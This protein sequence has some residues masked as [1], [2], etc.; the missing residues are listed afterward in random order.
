[1]I[2][3]R[4]RQEYVFLDVHKLVFLLL[5]VRLL[6]CCIDV[7]LLKYHITS[8]SAA[9]RGGTY[10]VWTIHFVPPSLM[11]L[12]KND[13]RF[14]NESNQLS[15]DQAKI[16]PALHEGLEKWTILLTISDEYFDFFQNWWW[17]FIRLNLEARVLVIAEDGNVFRKIM[18]NYSEYAYVERTELDIEEEML[19]DAEGRKKIAYSRISHILRYLKNGTNILYTD[20]DTVWLESPFKYFTGK[21]D[22]WIQMEDESIYSTG[23]MAISSN[24]NTLNFMHRWRKVLKTKLQDDRPVFNVL[25]KYMDI[26][27]CPLNEK[28]FASGPTYKTLSV[29]ERRNAAVVHNTNFELALWMKLQRFKQ[30]NLWNNETNTHL[31]NFDNIMF[32]EDTDNVPDSLDQDYI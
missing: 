14:D 3:F 32:L 10:K 21:C 8:N 30:W 1:M 19:F 7:A 13:S 2:R 17:F 29:S 25:F 6:L 11:H 28:K 12:M 27:P 24:K 16:Y 9:R 26:H 15:G 18:S 4:K 23:F 5:I 20:V 22:M 31:G